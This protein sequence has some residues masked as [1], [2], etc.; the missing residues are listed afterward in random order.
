V[1][2]AP[3]LGIPRFGAI[4]VGTIFLGLFYVLFAW[5]IGSRMPGALVTVL[6]WGMFVVPGFVVGFMARTSPVMHGVILGVLVVLAF[7]LAVMPWREAVSLLSA[8]VRQPG[9]ARGM[10]RGMAYWVCFGVVMCPL[11]AIVGSYAVRRMRGP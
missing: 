1:T 9:L 3:F 7:P 8:T 6:L 2:P 5:A 11:G 4:A 10:M